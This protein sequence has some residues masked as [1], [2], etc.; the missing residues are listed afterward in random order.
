MDLKNFAYWMGGA[1]TM[2]V[3]QLM[4]ALWEGPVD[5]PEP[6]PVETVAPTGERAYG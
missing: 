6:V 3:L 5:R 1:L 2:G 4:G